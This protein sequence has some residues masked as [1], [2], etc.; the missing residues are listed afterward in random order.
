MLDPGTYAG[1]YEPEAGRLCLDFANTVSWRGSDRRHDWLSS[2]SN[3]VDWGKLVDVLTD[4]EAQ[5]LHQAA[6]RDPVEAE[7]VL[8][9]A[10][11]LREAL[12]NIFSAVSTG[13]SPNSADLHTLNVALRGAS[14]YVQIISSNDGLDW[15]W[16]GYGDE[17]D[18]MLW[19]VARSA[20]NVLTGEDIQRVGECQGDGC[21]WLFMDMS[22]NRSRRWCDMHECGNRAKAV[23]HYWRKSKAVA[24]C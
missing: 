7:K 22:R 9:K 17:L 6:T 11:A 5:L 12:Y 20:A 16:G 3:L 23:R 24:R 13:L 2:Y 10:V 21:G 19:P 1:T 15:A 8:E 18:R 4:E 14:A